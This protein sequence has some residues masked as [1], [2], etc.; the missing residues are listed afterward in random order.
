MVFN[1]KVTFKFT[2]EDIMA[3]KQLKDML[4]KESDGIIRF[5]DVMQDIITD[6]D[7]R[8]YDFSKFDTFSIEVEQ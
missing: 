7:D 5:A 1:N 3:L 8:I 2:K 4:Y 6:P